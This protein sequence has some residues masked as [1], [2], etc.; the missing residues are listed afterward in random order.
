VSE[1]SVSSG[2]TGAVTTLLLT[3]RPAKNTTCSWMAH[4]IAPTEQTA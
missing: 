2:Q 4:V 1:H 3:T